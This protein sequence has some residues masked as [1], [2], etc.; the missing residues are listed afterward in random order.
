MKVICCSGDTIKLVAETQ[1][2]GEY[3]FNLRGD[4]DGN[5]DGEPGSASFKWLNI[6]PSKDEG[7]HE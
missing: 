5:G 7:S 3:L 4:L 1:F 6:H 2:E